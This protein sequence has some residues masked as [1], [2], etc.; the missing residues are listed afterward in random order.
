MLGQLWMVILVVVEVKDAMHG[1]LD[2]E[3]NE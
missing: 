1:E 2:D 3:G